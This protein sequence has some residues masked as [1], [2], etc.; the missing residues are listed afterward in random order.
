MCKSTDQSQRHVPL[1]LKDSVFHRVIPGF[2]CQGGDITAQDGTGGESI[3][4]ETFADEWEGGVVQH[5]E[6][7]LLR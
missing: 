4:G 1:H 2:M 3:Y 7:Y 5:S 6:P